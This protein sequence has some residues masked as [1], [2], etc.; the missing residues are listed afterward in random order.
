M[1]GEQREAVI[2]DSGPDAVT[3]AAVLADRA[4]VE[5]WARLL[6][7]IAQDELLAARDRLLVGVAYLDLGG[8]C[9]EAERQLARA[10]SAQSD[11]VRLLGWLRRQCALGRASSRAGS[12]GLVGATLA[13]RLRELGELTT[14]SGGGSPPEDATNPSDRAAYTRLVRQLLWAATA[15][16]EDLAAELA[17]GDA[18]DQCLAAHLYGDRL[19]HRARQGALLVGLTDHFPLFVAESLLDLAWADPT[20][21]AAVAAALEARELALAATS[22]AGERAATAAVRA[23][24]VAEGSG[25]PALLSA[26]QRARAWAEVESLVAR[27]GCVARAAA[28]AEQHLHRARGHEGAL[29]AALRLRAAQLLLAV[30][31][32]TRAEAALA[33]AD[34]ALLAPLVR[35]TRLLCQARLGQRAGLARALMALLVDL[36]PAAA[37]ATLEL[38]LEL[39]VDDPPALRAIAEQ[40][41]VLTREAPPELAWEAGGVLLAAARRLQA[42][43]LLREAW[44]T[45]GQRLTANH[46]RA[47]CAFAAL[48]A[49][50]RQGAV[51]AQAA[52]EAVDRQL[53]ALAERALPMSVPLLAVGA[54]RWPEGARW[55]ALATALLP[56]LSAAEPS[57]AVAVLRELA[58]QLASR[59]EGR[60]QAL[61]LLE[62]AVALLPDHAPTLRQLAA[63]Q[64]GCGQTAA[65]VATLQRAAGLV[66]ADEAAQLFVTIGN[67]L[68]TAPS[69]L[70]AAEQAYARAL[71]LDPA[72][73]E[74]L[75]A[76]RA[77]LA[78][79]DY[80]RRIGLLQGLLSLAQPPGERVSL[81][82]ELVADLRRRGE[83]RNSSADLQLALERCGEALAL[84]PATELAA[85][86]FAQLC[87]LNG[88]GQRLL[89]CADALQGTCA[90]RRALAAALVDEQRWSEAVTAWRAVAAGADEEPQER[91]AALLLAGSIARE[92]LGDAELATTLL[93]QAWALAPGAAA[94]FAPLYQVL[95]E[96]ER[97]AELA[98]LLREQCHSVAVEEALPL[99]LEL[100]RLALDRLGDRALARQQLDEVLAVQPTLLEAL[101]LLARALDHADG[102]RERVRVVDQIAAATEGQP[103]GLAPLLELAGLHAH[104]GDAV[105]ELRVLSS[106]QKHYPDDEAAFRYCEQAYARHSRWAELELLYDRRLAAL[107]GEGGGL[108]EAA[109][110]LLERKGHVELDRL[111]ARSSATDTFIQLLELRPGDTATLRLLEQVLREALDWSR[112][113]AVYERQASV[114][115]ERALQISFLRQAARV[116]RERLRDEAEALRLFERLY[117]LDPTDAEAFAALEGRLE[118]Q[119]DHR[120][121]VDLLLDHAASVAEPTHR[122]EALLRAAGICERIPDIDRALAIYRQAHLQE[123]TSAATLD[124]LARIYEARERWQELLEITEQQIALEPSERRRALLC[125]KCGSVMETQFN[126]DQD[127]LRYY[128]R[129]VKMSATCLPAL[130]GLRDLH[131]RRGEWD[132][133]ARTLEL[134][135]RIWKDPKGKADTLAR[136]GELYKERLNDPAKALS[137]YHRA[138]EVSADCLPAALALFEI[139]A[140]RGDAAEAVRWGEV[141]NRSGALRRTPALELRF[142]WRWARALLQCGRPTQAA[143]AALQSLELEPA[144]RDTLVLLLELCRVHPEC[145]DL[146][147]AFE[148]ISRTE[149][150]QQS[151]TALALVDTAFGTLAERRGDLE[152]ALALYRRAQ[153]Q[154]PEQLEVLRALADLLLAIGAG[155]EALQLVQQF[156]AGARADAEWVGATTWLASFELLRRSRPERAAALYREVLQ[157]MPAADAIR[158]QLVECL[159][160]AGAAPAAFAEML[161]LCE[162]ADDALPR[163]PRRHAEQLQLLGMAAYRSGRA[164]EAERHWRRAGEVL[165]QWVWAGLALAGRYFVAGD[166]RAA[167]RELKSAE[168]NA[169]SEHDDVIRAQSQFYAATGHP[170]RAVV[171]LQKICRGGQGAAAKAE[172]DDRVLLARLLAARGDYAQAVSTLRVAIADNPSYAEGYAE[173][174]RLAAS[175]GDGALVRRAAQVLE[176]ATG[177]RDERAIA[178]VRERAISPRGWDDMTRSWRE[179][180]CDFALRL[181]DEA[182]A[183]PVGGDWS[184]RQAVTQRPVLEA[185]DSAA[186]VL[187]VAGVL[188]ACAPEQP[189]LVRVQG[190]TVLL[191]SL[192]C[193]LERNE[194]RVLLLRAVAAVRL[195]YQSLLAGSPGRLRRVRELTLLLLGADEPPGS[196]GLQ[197]LMRRIPRRTARQLVQLRGRVGGTAPESF[198]RWLAS[199]TELWERLPLLLGEDFGAC[200]RVA[201]VADAFPP[202]IVR[203]GGLL[204]VSPTVLQLAQYYVSAGF[205]ED[206]VRLWGGEPS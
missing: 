47:V 129:A 87:Q 27:R 69:D 167:E 144:D 19:G 7:A 38:A 111:G 63:V 12:R 142:Y 125:F 191:S 151:P 23:L 17:E 115:A 107:A 3:T 118:R 201:L 114:V 102:A 5:E 195:G 110:E 82:L 104:L 119:E 22:F 136:L 43:P 189:A 35:R 83:E 162:G 157:R 127:A 97:W 90:G 179:S 80:D 131:A 173:L 96:A 2:R 199:I 48:G 74:A 64:V 138:I 29:A 20:P 75:H 153:Q 146:Q 93:Q 123:P 94:V 21:G 187:G 158:Q 172:I 8:A 95:A 140:D 79:E 76:L 18:V 135:A 67:L 184:Q 85:Q 154:A 46:E 41:L 58:E 44:L 50:V 178:P 62:R 122:L 186:R 192:A 6:A 148:Q 164:S 68:R 200:A 176:V 89:A 60:D 171:L 26:S 137:C 183:E 116:A 202:A 25:T 45:L 205:A 36:S 168:Q 55:Q 124:A 150:V 31:E 30:D 132:Q 170:E 34:D 139:H 197:E 88:Q 11:D 120:R 92:R 84:A 73:P 169:E 15:R 134:E 1:S 65:A 117:K 163:D 61:G 112:L 174:L 72:Q 70:P 52:G 165:P 14:P 105:A 160:L 143:E 152:G 56:A 130:H 57:L 133:V 113:V 180:P 196:S 182:F 149:P 204:A 100:A 77:L 24:M 10:A 155:D 40:L 39:A 59:S 141:C 145:Y 78:P 66:A 53:L 198:D 206:Q 126:N 193:G 147:Q 51:A 194:L 181:I 81:L 177:N 33:L 101:R 203:E 4:P 98:T 9:A 86:H 13:E 190:S 109:A 156:R 42:T 166:L 108:P 71:A 128:T 106:L 175:R 32:A 159:L 121:L 99:R 16:W 37:A 161:P 188:I 103:E 185:L 54:L 28:L 91:V 49:S